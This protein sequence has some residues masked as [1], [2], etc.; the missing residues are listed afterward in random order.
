MSKPQIY[1]DG[2]FATDLSQLKVIEKDYDTR[3]LIFSFKSRPL[4][5][6]NPETDEEEMLPVQDAPVRTTPFMDSEQLG[7]Y[8]QEWLEAWEKYLKNK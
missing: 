1:S 5:R 6:Q 4:F 3:Q 7:V 8:Y 2:C